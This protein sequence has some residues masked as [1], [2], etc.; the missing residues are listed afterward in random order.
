VTDLKLKLERLEAK[1]GRLPDT[2]D[3]SL[4]AVRQNIWDWDRVVKGSHLTNCWYQTACNY[5]IYV[6]DG[7]VLRE[8]QAANYPPQNDPL[9][10]D[11]NPRGCQKGS[12]Y[13][14]RIYDPTRIKYPMKRVGE[15]GQGKW[16]RISWD[17]ALTE[18]AD[19][20]I[21]TATKEGPSAIVQGGGTRVMNIGSEG[22][23]PTAFFVGLGSPLSNVTADNGDDHQG[24]AI[25][26]GKVIV[27]DSADN[28][29]YSDMILIWGGNPAYTN[30]PNYHFIAEARYNGTKVVTISPDYSP[31][32]VHADQWVPVNIGSDAALALSMSQ[33]IIKEKLFKEDFVREQTDLPL[34][35]VESTGR[36]LREKDF[37]AG[38]R[39][40]TFYFWDLSSGKL[41][42]APRKSLALNGM[43]PALQGSYK[44]ETPQGSVTV[45][46][47]MEILSA[48]LDR[49][50]TPEQAGQITGLSSRVIEQLAREVATAKG[51]VNI[52]TANWG[53][54]YHGDLI[55][56]AIL[57]VFA[58]C[59]HMGR[60]GATFSA[61]PMMGLDTS[62][63][64]LEKR[65]DQIILSAAGGDPRFAQWREE[66]FTDEMILYEYVHQAFS[67][68]GVTPTSLM[69]YIHG[70]ILDLCAKH[71]EWDPD[72]KRPIKEY[73]REAF[74]KKWQFL[75]PGLDKEPKVMFAL[76]GNFLRRARCTNTLIETFLP[77]LRLLV[78]IDWRWNSSALY[79]DLV[80][81]AC[82]WYEKTSTFLMGMPVQPFVHMVNQ[83][84]EPLYDSMGEWKMFCLLARKVEERAS[85]RGIP[86][87]KDANGVEHRFAGLEE[88]VTFGGLYSEDD[89]EGIARDAFLNA[90]NVE[91]I[92]WEEFKER[93][94]ARYTGV[95]T[96]MRSIGNTC[97]IVPGEPVVPLTWHTERK[98]PYPTLTR[99]IQFLIDHEL[100][101]ELGE[102]LPVHKDP[103]PAGGNYPLKLTGGH[104]RWS[105]H[106][107]QVDE[108][109]LLQLQRGGPLMFMSAKDAL[110]R[111]I[112][113]G[114][115][116]EVSNDVASFQVQVA[117][118]PAVR[119][120][121]VIIY[122]A[123]E[124]YQ[125][126]G[127]RH[128]KSVMASPMNPV[129][130][131]GDYFQIR[132]ITMSNYPG[133]SDRG[134]R[135]EV[136][137]ADA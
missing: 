137:R 40:D 111:G 97:D 83:A 113:D 33:V 75:S 21:D 47:F 74:D 89:E 106:S 63:G 59:G 134:T 70:G 45:K 101:R 135:V 46:P 131:A 87:Y 96:G 80:L 30:I 72:I 132:P 58:L 120:G 6:K 119:P 100:F 118:S 1:E 82:S 18:V 61:F 42:E 36:F 79:A 66:G 115:T 129:E 49:N 25:T 110:S 39:E 32:A 117:V 125:F 84:T 98:D 12:C 44:V 126:K 102:D 22:T 95:G 51:V 67:S 29:F 11:F 114:D 78:S 23:G 41:T 19:A 81:P 3:F 76:G 92:D 35:V 13:V 9:A 27:G 90:S 130:L 54:C 15:R 136:R 34:L 55:E 8:E 133:F 123:W 107:D 73:V 53:K 50:Y 71:P 65:G 108:T 20:I 116:V 91:Q 4:G 121:Q 2:P 105:I 88:K 26:L 7:V 37:K 103:P 14:H 62:L 109:L 77:K 10:P 16:K 52:S 60:K 43:I 56:R 112:R 86:S 94:I 85:E 24:V 48:H 69:Y 99:R 38:G 124:N 127:W 104:A 64:G 68:G 5:N 28:W 57:M 128:F 122:H 31:S 93:G 17:E